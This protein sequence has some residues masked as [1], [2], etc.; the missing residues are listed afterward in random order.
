MKYRFAIIVL[1]FIAL[2]FVI[3]SS[4]TWAQNLPGGI[5]ASPQS[6]ATEGR[7]RSN[8]DDFIRPDTHS[9]LKF[10]KWFGMVAFKADE[11]HNPKASIGFAG[12]ASGLYIGA[13]Y[14]GNFWAGT[15]ANN[16]TERQFTE[17]NEP[18]GGAANNVY[19]V[20][21]NINVVSQ[22]DNNIALLLGFADMGLRLTYRTNHL[23]FSQSGIVTGNQLYNNYYAENGYIAPQI[24]WAVSKDMVSGK[25]IRP[26]VTI[27][28][29]FDRSYLRTE[30]AGQDA[31]GI[32]GVKIGRSANVF[33]PAIGLGLGG[34]HFF[35]QDGFRATLDLDYTFTTSI[36]DNEYSYIENGQYK[37]GK[38][39]GTY[40]PG[41]FPYVERSYFTNTLTPSIAGSWSKEKLAL[42]FKLNIPLTLAIDEAST[43][44]VNGSDLIRNGNSDTTTTFTIRP[45]IRL[46]LQYKLIPDRL[47]LNAGARIQASALTLETV[48]HDFYNADGQKLPSYTTKIHRDS[49]GSSIASRFH[50]GPTFFFTENAWVEANTG[51][52]NAYGDNAIEIFAAGGLF[53]FGSILVCLKF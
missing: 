16:Y 1:L 14:S 17:G 19:N 46:A 51:V 4:Y 23:L 49:F 44:A 10:E 35:N 53:S 28:L 37:T 18:A 24:A 9:N 11:N 45:D 50:I 52:S 15:P 31:D 34:F 32:T 22:S 48:D 47:T 42:R 7:Y 36:Y 13:F 27:E 30:T 40:N 12:K 5:W 39:G 2:L 41:S 3:A 29:F 21:N 20:Y 33:S 43:M 8:A 26:Y 6:D 25:G 38:I